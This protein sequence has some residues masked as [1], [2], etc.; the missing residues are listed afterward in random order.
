MDDQKLLPFRQAQKPSLC[1]SGQRFLAFAD[2]ARDWAM[3]KRPKPILLFHDTFA[4]PAGAITKS[5]ILSI[6]FYTNTD[7]VPFS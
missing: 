4:A 2:S 5:M 6:P 3:T 7:A 1:F